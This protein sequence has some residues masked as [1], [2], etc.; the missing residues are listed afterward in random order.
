MSTKYFLLSKHNHAGAS[1]NEDNQ[2]VFL[3]QRKV[4][5]LPQVNLEYYSKHGLFESALMD[6]CSQFMKQD[7]LFLDIGAHTGTY[8]ISFSHLFREIHAFE[9]QRM[10][11]NALCGGIA[12]SHCSNIFAHRFGLGSPEQVGIQTLK[13]VSNDGGGSSLHHSDTHKILR[14]ETIEIRTLDSLGLD[15]IG[16]IKMD[17]EDNELF[18]L[19][20]GA[21]TI[22]R[23]GCPPIVFESNHENVELFEYLKSEFG[24]NVFSISGSSNMYLASLQ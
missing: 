1:N 14:T 7:K 21:E 10:T 12:L 11:Y 8:S 15:N 18:V 13:I 20:G 3:N 19:K 6:W 23:S 16:F 2:L 24:Y 4:Y 22:R 17:V 9:P 5:I